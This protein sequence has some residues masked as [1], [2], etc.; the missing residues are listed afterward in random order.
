MMIPKQAQVI[1]AQVAEGVFLMIHSTSA[2]QPM[3][4]A[5]DVA[6]AMKNEPEMLLG[7]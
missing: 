7:K 5:I 6:I 1:V 4:I 3:V 2:H